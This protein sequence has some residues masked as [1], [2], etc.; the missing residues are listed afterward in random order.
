MKPPDSATALWVTLVIVAGTIGYQLGRSPAVR[1]AA[2]GQAL[3]EADR[4]FAAETAA[5]G[6]EGWLAWFA[7][8]G[9]MFPDG[10]EIVHGKATIRE[11]MTPVLGPP[12]NSLRWEPLGGELAD[13][14]D[15]GYTYGHS[16]ARRNAEGRLEERP[17]KYV[18]VWKKQPDGQWR[19]ALD[20]GNRRPQP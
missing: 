4:A 20:I 16:V 13:S 9:R 11:L 17:G 3:I 19:V 18:T 8:D 7:E 2:D 12:E 5:R 6:V 1:A 15:L 14:G 10:R